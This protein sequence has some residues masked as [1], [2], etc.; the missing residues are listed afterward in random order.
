MKEREDYWQDE[1]DELVDDDLPSEED[2]LNAALH[3]ADMARDDM[4]YA[5]YTA[6]IKGSVLNAHADYI[7]TLEEK[8]NDE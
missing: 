4:P 8:N 2:K 6:R 1:Y 3:R 5:D 7:K